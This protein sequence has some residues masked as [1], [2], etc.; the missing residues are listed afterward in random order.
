ML[1]EF[2]KHLIFLPLSKDIRLIYLCKCCLSNLNDLQAVLVGNDGA[3]KQPV[4]CQTLNGQA[5]TT[6]GEYKAVCYIDIE[7]PRNYGSKI[8]Y[9]LYSKVI[10]GKI[11]TE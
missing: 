9:R 8:Y 3:F 2:T 4:K 1:G 11:I 6:A 7:L 10:N 5:I